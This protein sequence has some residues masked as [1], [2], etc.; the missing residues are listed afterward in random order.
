MLL[1]VQDLRHTATQSYAVALTERG[2]RELVPV[3]PTK[4]WEIHVE[5][6]REMPRFE[7]AAAAGFPVP[8]SIPFEIDDEPA[9][10]L[11]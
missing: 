2:S 9:A 5:F 1:R 3:S 6:E 4:A 11:E 10:A 8:D 7:A